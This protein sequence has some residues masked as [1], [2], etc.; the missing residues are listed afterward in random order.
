MTPNHRFLI[1]RLSRGDVLKVP[2]EIMG[3]LHNNKKKTHTHIFFVVVKGSPPKTLK[4]TIS[5]KKI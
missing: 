5:K 1:Q 3:R 4:R 2:G